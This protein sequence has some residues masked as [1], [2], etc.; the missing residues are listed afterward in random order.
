MRRSPRIEIEVSS[1]AIII[2]IAVAAVLMSTLAAI[3][4]LAIDQF[5][6]RY[7]DAKGVLMIL[8]LLIPVLGFNGL[9][10]AA[11]SVRGRFITLCKLAA[12]NL[13]LFAILLLAIV[14]SCGAAGAAMAL[15]LGEI[16]NSWIQARILRPRVA[17][18]L[19]A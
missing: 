14:P 17:W 8:T 9:C 15:L 7:R 3:G 10:T 5:L 6:P 18:R 2:G 19:N 1:K 4:N 16:C 13:V 11:L 12:F